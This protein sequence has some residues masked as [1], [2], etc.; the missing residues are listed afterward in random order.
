MKNTIKNCLPL[1]ETASPQKRCPCG[2]LLAMLIDDGIE[3]K[4]KRCKRLE[5]IS[6]DDLINFFKSRGLL[7]P[8]SSWGLGPSAKRVGY[9]APLNKEEI[10]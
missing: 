6:L 2:Q 4:C 3:I 5:T 1:K 9:L 10:K 7:S 8:D